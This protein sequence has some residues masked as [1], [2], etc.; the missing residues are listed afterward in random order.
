[1][2][3]WLAFILIREESIRGDDPTRMKLPRDFARG[4]L[5]GELPQPTDSQRFSAGRRYATA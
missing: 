1:M 3:L 2:M 4:D 5:N